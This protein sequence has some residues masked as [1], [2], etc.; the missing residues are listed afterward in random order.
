M[1]TYDADA[2]PNPTDW[3]ANSESEKLRLVRSFHLMGGAKSRDV[4]GHAASHVVV[5]D[6]VA[7]GFGP[8]CRA[9]VRMQSRGVSRHEAVHAVAEVVLDCLRWE[10]ES[11]ADAGTRHREM[12]ARIEA[13]ATLPQGA[14][15]SS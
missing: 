13:L 6:Q 7:R 1:T 15:E 11:T 4:K 10:P 12:N 8:T 14:R 2:P 3:L 5:E 9:I